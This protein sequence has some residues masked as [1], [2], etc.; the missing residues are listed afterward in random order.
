MVQLLQGAAFFILGTMSA[1]CVWLA[2]VVLKTPEWEIH[3][4]LG[5]REEQ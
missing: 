3:R 5:R 2:W 4:L 1:F